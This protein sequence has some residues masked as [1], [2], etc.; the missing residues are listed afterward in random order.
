MI[1]TTTKYHFVVS[2]MCI[3]RKMLLPDVNTLDKLDSFPLADGSTWKH[4]VGYPGHQERHG[5]YRAGFGPEWPTEYHA[6][7]RQLYSA[8]PQS[9]AGQAQLWPEHVGAPHDS[10]EEPTTEAHITAKDQHPRLDWCKL[11]WQMVKDALP[12]CFFL[13]Q[14]CLLALL[15][16]LK[17]KKQKGHQWGQEQTAKCVA[18]FLFVSDLFHFC[19]LVTLDWMII[20]RTGSVISWNTTFAG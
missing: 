1:S 14:H 18:H 15:C 5:S 7:I 20:F 3:I 16:Q 8:V 13:F 6:D 10:K 2:K 17:E 4:L 19:D 9:G 11:Y 12:N